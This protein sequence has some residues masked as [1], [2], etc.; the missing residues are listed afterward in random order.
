MSRDARELLRGIVYRT[1]VLRVYA[2]ARRLEL[3]A[4]GQERALEHYKAH[5]AELEAQ[6]ATL[7]ARVDELSE[8]VRGLWERRAA[9]NPLELFLPVRRDEIAVT[10]KPDRRAGPSTPPYELNWVITPPASRTSGGHADI[11]RAIAHLDARGHRSRVYFYDPLNAHSAE[12]LG[13]SIA[14]Y[15]RVQAE[16]HP[17]TLSMAPC[18]AIIATGWPTA[19]PVRAFAAAARKIYFVQDYEPY[20]VAS[21]TYSALAASTYDFGFHGLTLGDWLAEKLR[22]D[23]AMACDA[24]PFGVDTTQYRLHDPGPRSLRVLFYARPSS[25][26]RGF[27]LGVLAL[28]QFHKTHP[29]CEIELIGEEIDRW[30]LPFPCTRHGVL[31]PEQLCELYNRCSAGLVL[32]FTNMSL[33][34]LELLACGCLP[35]VNDA[36]NTRAVPFADDLHFAEPTPSA[37][38]AALERA[39]LAAGRAEVVSGAA[40]RARE[41]DWEQA[42]RRIEEVLRE[43]LGA[44]V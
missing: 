29:D 11:F 41:L 28:E 39:S 8:E 35:V 22:R 32:S 27:E 20:F 17:D 25:A 44:G 26:R 18:D 3:V 19:Y 40:Q 36:A 1:P 6:N 14:P 31:E 34:P 38:A 21:G 7:A 15:A 30:Q 33:V 12:Q 37:L 43:Q 4:E 16:L 5:T 10:T 24:F 13:E 42:N 9:E 2:K 23:H